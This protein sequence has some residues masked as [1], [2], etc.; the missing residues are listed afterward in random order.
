M[1]QLPRIIV[2]DHRE[3]AR[4]YRGLRMASDQAGRSA[5]SLLI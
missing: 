3:Q 1:N 5:A 4:S 2:G